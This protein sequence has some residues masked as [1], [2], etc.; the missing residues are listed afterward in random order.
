MLDPLA[1]KAMII[2]AVVTLSQ[3]QWAVPGHRLPNWLVVAVVAKDL[4]VIFGF[5]VIYLVTDRI[6]IRPT[7]AGK[8]CTFGQ[9][10]LVGLTLLGPNLEQAPGPIGAWTLAVVSWIV[11][12]LC[13][14]A[15]ISYTRLGLSFIA[16]EQKPLDNNHDQA[17]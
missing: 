3:P 6:R 14:L 7:F 8:A 9:V 4:W 15:I 12:G 13:C 1:D 17:R 5:I 2:C 16:A 11:A 10:W